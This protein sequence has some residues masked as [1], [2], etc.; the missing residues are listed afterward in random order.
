MFVVVYVD[1]IIVIGNDAREISSL[2]VYL[3]TAFK[4]KDLGFVNYF[5]GLEV[6]QS[7]QG[8]VL[9]RR[10]FTMELLSEFLPD[11]TTAISPP[12][13]LYSKSLFV[14]TDPYPDPTQYRQLV[15]KL[16]FLTH[17]RPDI[18]F[19]VQYLSQF[20]HTPSTSHY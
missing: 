5:L 7:T 16:N 11:D 17:T 12:L 15:G 3:N 4:I 14:G 6:L 2:K 10:K 19:S 9:T 8:V 1:D 13:D 20:L 18:A